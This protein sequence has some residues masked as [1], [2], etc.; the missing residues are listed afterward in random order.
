MNKTSQKSTDMSSGF[1]ELDDDLFDVDAPIKPSVEHEDQV[2]SSQLS[3]PVTFRKDLGQN[4]SFVSRDDDSG[5]NSSPSMI[6][7]VSPV[8]NP[9]FGAESLSSSFYTPN[10]S[11]ST[12]GENAEH[13]GTPN[14]TGWEGERTD[15]STEFE[16][17]DSEEIAPN[18]DE[19]SEEFPFVSSIPQSILKLHRGIREYEKCTD[20]AFAYAIAGQMCL[21]TFPY[22]CFHSAKLAL[23]LSI[24]STHVS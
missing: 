16:F 10:A 20:Y 18:S 23:T 24:I 15:S 22:D 13:D 1:D 17:M 5:L 12:I 9:V 14:T 6:E 7:P 11:Q 8:I 3:F 21:R 2:Y 19:G 4:L